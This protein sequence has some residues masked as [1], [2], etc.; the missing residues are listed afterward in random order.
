MELKGWYFV[1][2]SPP[3]DTVLSQMNL[4]HILTPYLS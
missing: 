4:V 1:H 2:K 3:L